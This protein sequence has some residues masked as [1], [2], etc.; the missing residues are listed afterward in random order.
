MELLR[1][2][3]ALTEPPSPASAGLADALELGAPPTAAEHADLFTFQLYPYASVYLSA[4]GMLGGEAR[5]RVAGFWR[6]LGLEPPPE[7]DHLAVLLA[8][9][10]R[11]AE[12]E[13]HA[14]VETQERWRHARRA[15]LAEHLLSW[16]P[17]YLSRVEEIAAPFY[18][19]WARLLDQAL[20][21]E[22]QT[23]GDPTELPPSLHLRQA[24]PFR[25][26]RTEGGQALL[27]DLLTPIRS[28]LILTRT[29]L[30]R[31]AHD[32]D[33][34]LRQGERRYVLTALLTQDA[35]A[36]LGWLAREAQRQAEVLAGSAM[37]LRNV[38]PNHWRDRAVATARLLEELAQDDNSGE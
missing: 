5:D 9:Q 21:A 15:H 6:A 38:T 11:L 25:D 10:T 33:L 7:P 22:A 31:A 30:A 28:G 2:L 13:D 32:L 17:A 23:L 26:P 18:R 27:E 37:A 3:G 16:L 19:R 24:P 14:P 29:D 36:I 35:P 1:A 4:E 20:A 12:L 34:G 8:L